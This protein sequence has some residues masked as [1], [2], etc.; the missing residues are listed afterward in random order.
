MRTLATHLFLPNQSNNQ[1]PRILHPQALAI[2]LVVFF[3]LQMGF[4]VGKFVYPNILGYATNITVENLLTLTNQKRQEAG[5]ASLN[6][7]PILSAAAF[8]KAE[9]MFFKN[10]WSHVAP[11]GKTPWQ[12]I[13][14]NGYSYLYAGENLAKDFANSNGVVAAWMASASHKDN[15]LKKEYE[16]IGFAVVNGKLND[17]ETTL[18]VQ[19]FGKAKTLAQKPLLIPQKAAIAKTP[20]VSLAPTLVPSPTFM[21]T[22]TPTMVK[23]PPEIAVSSFQAAPSQKALVDILNVE[24]SLSLGLVTLLLSVLTVDSLFILKRK[25]VRV[26]GKN[27]AHIIFLVTLIGLIFLTKHGVIL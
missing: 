27:F 23:L 19:M 15:I 14:G 16:D 11:D 21:L 8:K 5:L 6:L 9:D 17:Q 24:R 3:V 1:R 18:V 12:F 26:V 25:T 4:R 7:D 13:E 20:P 2:Y 10:Y 22:P